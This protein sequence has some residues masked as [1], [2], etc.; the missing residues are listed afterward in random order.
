MK[1]NYDKEYVLKYWINDAIAYGVLFIGIVFI[2][3]L[4]SAMLA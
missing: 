3:I 1:L 4:V 2:L